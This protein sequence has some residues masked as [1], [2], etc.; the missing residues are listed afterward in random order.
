MVEAL[1]VMV[2]ILFLTVV[3]DVVRSKLGLSEAASRA[4]LVVY[5]LVVCVA[6]GW[7]WNAGYLDKV[8]QYVNKLL[9]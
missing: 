7:A 5:V 6:C 1:G 4:F 8:G 2:A 9:G 3:H